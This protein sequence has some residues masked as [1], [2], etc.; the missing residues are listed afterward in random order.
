MTRHDGRSFADERIELDCTGFRNCRFARCELVYAGGPPPELVNCHFEDCNWAFTGSA[1]VTL[2]F[3]SALHRGGF[4]ALVENT[5]EMA[6]RGD[7]LPALTEEPK[8]GRAG[9]K[10]HPLMFRVPRVL[11]LRRRPQAED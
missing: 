1:A 2:G 8:E 3:L 11:K 9:A 10:D 5:F 6:R 4:A 7:F